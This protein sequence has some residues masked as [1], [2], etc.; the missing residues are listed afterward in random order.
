M[1]LLPRHVSAGEKEVRS[2]LRARVERF[3]IALRH[4]LPVTP[5]VHPTLIPL[6]VRDLEKD[7]QGQAQAGS[8][9]NI[10]ARVVLPAFHGRRTSPAGG[11]RTEENNDITTSA[12]CKSAVPI[13]FLGS[14]CKTVECSRIIR[15]ASPMAM[16]GH[17]SGESPRN[18]EQLVVR[19]QYLAISRKN[20]KDNCA[21][22]S[23]T[24]RIDRCEAQKL[25]NRGQSSRARAPTSVALANATRLRADAVVPSL[26][27]TTLRSTEQRVE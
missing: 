19:L 6:L 27:L 12:Q 4:R 20:L 23:L 2:T 18:R 13:V 5:P 22:L 16:G 17:G 10:F 9:T 7:C 14:I 24:R 11:G 26:S 1:F 15:R 25:H 8:V 3:A 21:G